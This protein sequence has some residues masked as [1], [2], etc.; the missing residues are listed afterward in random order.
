LSCPPPAALQ[1]HLQINQCV[2]TD[3]Q[4]ATLFSAAFP[5]P[6][7]NKVCRLGSWE[8]GEMGSLEGLWASRRHRSP[9]SDPPP[10]SNNP[11]VNLQA[12]LEALHN[13]LLID[14]GSAL[15]WLGPPYGGGAASPAAARLI[16]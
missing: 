5:Y 1:N 7:N 16:G 2:L 9:L 3:E 15:P 13:M 4:R 10:Q 8:G 6:L 11:L 14:G 12:M